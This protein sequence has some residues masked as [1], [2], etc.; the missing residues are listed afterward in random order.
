MALFHHKCLLSLCLVFVIKMA[1]CLNKQTRIV[2]CFTSRWAFEGAEC[3]RNYTVFLL[4]KHWHQFCTKSELPFKAGLM[5]HPVVFRS[6]SLTF[7]CASV[8]FLSFS[9]SLSLLLSCSGCGGLTCMW[10]FSLFL[11]ADGRLCF[12]DSRAVSVLDRHTL[13]DRHGLGGLCLQ[14]CTVSFSTPAPTET[15]LS[16]QTEPDP[17][18]PLQSVYLWNPQPPPPTP[19]SL[20]V[21]KQSCVYFSWLA[22]R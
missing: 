14:P 11:W 8:H 4:H 5:T 21:W 17:F 19:T 20:V 18:R 15:C 3:L 7:C 16:V 22:G 13:P 1:S 6:L 10:C 9:L 2:F 12:W